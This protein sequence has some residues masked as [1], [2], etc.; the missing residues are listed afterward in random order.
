MRYQ[1]EPVRSRRVNTALEAIMRETD[2]ASLEIGLTS[3]DLGKLYRARI[4]PVARRK[5]E[6][7]RTADRP[8]RFPIFLGSALCALLVGS[9]PVG[10][11]TP[12]RWAWNRLMAVVLIGGLTIAVAG[13]GQ[14]RPSPSSGSGNTAELFVA[15]GR[16]AYNAKQ[17]EEALSHFEA[18]IARAPGNPIPRYD[19]AAALF[20]LQR[21][22]EALERYQQSRAIADASLRTKID[23]A[24]GNTMLIMGN[25]PGAVGSYDQCLASS[26]RG[27]D[28][29]AV[30]RD[31]TINRQFALEHIP[32]SV[33]PEAS[34]KADRPQ[35]KRPQGAG[36]KPGGDQPGV[37]DVPGPEAAPPGDSGEEPDEAGKRKSRT[38]GA[39]GS[40]KSQSSKR[41]PEDRL[42]DALDRIRES[43]RRRLSDE[44]P[45]EAVDRNRKDW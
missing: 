4:A 18:A 21:Y 13:A 5:R 23:Y 37:D 20:Q 7:A 17:F 3:V 39:G 27:E 34:D 19:A 36:R 43:Q 22:P 45:E 35:E 31:A 6:A 25:V 28:L 41:P 30:R 14:G 16:A 42:N 9:W 26:A 1:G 40:S 2:G 44:P 32:P 38:G 12:W 24:V 33:A 10:R 29:K 15:Q 11:I 8:E